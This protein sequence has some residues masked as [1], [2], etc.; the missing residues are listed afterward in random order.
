MGSFLDQRLVIGSTHTKEYFI[1]KPNHFITF[2][3]AVPPKPA[4]DQVY[5]L[6]HPFDPSAS[7]IEPLISPQFAQIPAV[8][9]PRYHRFPL[10]DGQ[11]HLLNKVFTD[12]PELFVSQ[13]GNF[14]SQSRPGLVQR[15]SNLSTVSLVSSDSSDSP[16]GGTEFDAGMSKFLLGGAILLFKKVL[17]DIR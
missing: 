6:F 5:N 11:S 9:V 3:T 15:D 16:R 8:S 10:G 1:S 7:R 4:C 14:R 17:Q 13:P 12:N 2:F